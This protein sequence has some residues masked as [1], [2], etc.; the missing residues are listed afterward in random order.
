MSK[1]LPPYTSST[2]LLKELFKKIQ[3]APPPPRFS[4]DFLFSNFKFK[5]SGSTNAFIP[6]LKRLGFLSSDG[7]PTEIYKQFR[8]PN[9]KISGGAMAEAIK[10]GY[11]ELY[12]RNE[13]WHSLGKAEFKNF[14][15]EVLELE[16]KNP[17]INFITSTVECL[18]SFANFEPESIPRKSTIID[19]EQ[20]LN[21]ENS[22][23]QNLVT[24]GLNLSYTINLN[25]PESSDI[26]VFDAIFMSL[27]K[28]ILNK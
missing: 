18:K 23:N 24:G 13:Y 6:M 8:N 27:K 16:V 11:V 17:V 10:N 15:I 28:H 12:N 7:S 19:N 22:N 3:E 2:G 1:E 25:L 21:L 20:D 14:I 5:K 9:P 4:L 26:K